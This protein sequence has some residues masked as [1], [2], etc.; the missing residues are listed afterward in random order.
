MTRTSLKNKIQALNLG[1]QN[2][3][4]VARGTYRLWSNHLGKHIVICFD[5]QY[6]KDAREF[7]GDSVYGYEECRRL[8][9]KELTPD[10]L[11]CIDDYKAMFDSG[12]VIS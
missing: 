2:G 8:L 6:L 10:N 11:R 4:H 1:R 9:S 7:L 12:A 3:V 5:D